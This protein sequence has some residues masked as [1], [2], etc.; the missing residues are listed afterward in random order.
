MII[1]IPIPTFMPISTGTIS[2]ASNPFFFSVLVIIFIVLSLI[3]IKEL[4]IITKDFIKALPSRINNYFKEKKDKK[5]REKLAKNLR[6]D[7]YETYSEMKSRD[8]M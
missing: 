4:Y 8:L 2:L 3:I 5:M 1:P 6:K 7:F